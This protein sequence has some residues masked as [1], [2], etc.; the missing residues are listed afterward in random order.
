MR[1]IPPLPPPSDAVNKRGHTTAPPSS[2]LVSALSTRQ[3]AHNSRTLSSASGCTTIAKT[4]STPPAPGTPAQSTPG[5]ADVAFTSFVWTGGSIGTPASC[6]KRKSNSQW[7]QP[8]ARTLA[9]EGKALGG[10]GSAHI[11]RQRQFKTANRVCWLKHFI[12]AVCR[13]AKANNIPY[14]S[15]FA[16]E[17]T[18]LGE[19]CLEP[20]ELLESIHDTKCFPSRRFGPLA[21]RKGRQRLGVVIEPADRAHKRV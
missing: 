20:K 11:E 9:L 5:R 15:H 12:T 17:L 1:T 21:G 3:L 19:S 2:L 4:A 6:K 10:A 7:C 13:I 14:L 16:Q 18:S 8:Y